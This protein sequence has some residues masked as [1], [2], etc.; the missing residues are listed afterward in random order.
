LDYQSN[1]TKDCVFSILW[2]AKAMP[3]ALIIVGRVLLDRIPTSLNMLR[4][5]V[6]VNSSLCVFCSLSKESSQHLFLD[7]VYVQR[8]WSICYR[9]GVQNK[10]LRN[11]F[12]NF[13]LVHLLTSKIRYGKE[14]GLKH[15]CVPFRM[16]FR[17]GN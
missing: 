17:I 8:V 9:S 4:G 2:P 14:C 5:G 10:D 13:H 15:G 1:G 6:V 7:C 12:E 11:H 3:K 16:R